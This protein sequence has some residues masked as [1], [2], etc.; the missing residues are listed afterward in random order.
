MVLSAQLLHFLDY[1]YIAYSN[2]TDIAFSGLDID[3]VQV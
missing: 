3:R 1:K 2:L